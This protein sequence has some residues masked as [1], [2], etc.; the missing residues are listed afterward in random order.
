MAARQR[1]LLA[2][3]RLRDAPEFAPQ[4]IPVKRFVP[5]MQ[6]F[7]DV[8][9]RSFAPNPKGR[10]VDDSV[11]DPVGISSIRRWQLP[12]TAVPCGNLTT[13]ECTKRFPVIIAS[14]KVRRRRGGFLVRH[15]SVSSAMKYGFYCIAGGS[16]SV[17]HIARRAPGPRSGG[18]PTRP[19]TCS[20]TGSM[21][22]AVAGLRGQVHL[23]SKPA[24]MWAGS[25]RLRPGGFIG[26]GTRRLAAALVRS[27]SSASGSNSGMTAS[28]RCR[29]GPL[30]WPESVPE[31]GLE[32]W[33]SSKLRPT[34]SGRAA[35]IGARIGRGCAAYLCR[36]WR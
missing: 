30:S 31:L 23:D 8:T 7:A 21:R 28:G 26:P 16:R 4:V 19:D 14:G 20:A 34:H 36:W 3:D 17:Q 33:S 22:A 12:R 13:S 24:D 35:R 18:R 10:I 32:V 6:Y 2:A 15:S 27:L 9:I 11:D 29:A 25:L 1:S 5:R